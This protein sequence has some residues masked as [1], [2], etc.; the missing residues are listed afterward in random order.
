VIRDQDEEPEVQPM[1]T[2]EQEQCDQE[3][4]MALVR[5]QNT[6]LVRE[7]SKLQE[8]ADEPC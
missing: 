3:L 6:Q 8:R 1:V 7:Q 2:T 5:I 4:G